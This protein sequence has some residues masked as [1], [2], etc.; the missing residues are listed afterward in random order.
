[1]CRLLVCTRVQPHRTIAPTWATWDTQDPLTLRP[2]GYPASLPPGTIAHKL[3]LRNVQLKA[4][5]GRYVALFDGEGSLDFGFDAKVRWIVPPDQQHH[6]VQCGGLCLAEF[7]E[8]TGKPQ[9]LATC[10]RYTH[11]LQ[12]CFPSHAHLVT[13]QFSHTGYCTAVH[14]AIVQVSS[15]AK[16]R[17][18]FEYRPTANMECHATGAAYCEWQNIATQDMQAQPEAGMQH[19]TAQQRLRT[20]LSMDTVSKPCCWSPTL[21]CLPASLP[22][23]PFSHTHTPPQVVTTAS[24]SS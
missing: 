18:E 10:C 5:P 20:M 9:Q 15:V 16:G 3:A 17:V 22:R 19:H 12:C 1:M 14:D 8:S 24:G 11:W 7:I 21:L 6:C 4:M 2:D 23:P 13:W